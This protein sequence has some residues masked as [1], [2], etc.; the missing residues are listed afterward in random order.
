MDSGTIYFGGWSTGE[1][2]LLSVAYVKYLGRELGEPTV[3][4]RTS[5]EIIN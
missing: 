2:I 5:I 3:N 4:I 1:G